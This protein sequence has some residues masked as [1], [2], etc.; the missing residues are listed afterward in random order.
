MYFFLFVF[1]LL[2]IFLPSFY[3]F[4]FSSNLFVWYRSN[5]AIAGHASS[6][7]RYRVHLSTMWSRHPRSFYT[8]VLFPFSLSKGEFAANNLSMS[9]YTY[10]H[11]KYLCIQITKIVVRPFSDDSVAGVW[12]GTNSAYCRVEC[13]SKLTILYLQDDSVLCRL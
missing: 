10:T 4:F 1:L 7:R 12:S 5:S 8:N 11:I 3:F 13:V 9:T 6:A 2:F